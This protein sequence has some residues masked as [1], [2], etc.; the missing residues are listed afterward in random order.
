LQRIATRH[1]LLTWRIPLRSASSISSRELLR[2][3][4]CVS[5]HAFLREGKNESSQLDW[6]R[7][8]CVRAFVVPHFLLGSGNKSARARSRDCS[9]TVS[10]WSVDLL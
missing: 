4:T 9:S 8:A 6:L 3:S 2:P 1:T 5:A 10:R 7:A